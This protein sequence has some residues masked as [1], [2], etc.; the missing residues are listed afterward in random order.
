MSA[1]ACVAGH[2]PEPVGTQ[3]HH[4]V[5]VS[6]VRDGGIP[7]DP[8]TVALCGTAHDNVHALLNH[9][10]RRGG[11]PVWEIRRQFGPYIR[12]LAAIAWERRPNEKPP[13]TSASGE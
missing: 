13:W 2:S 8:E 4:V 1:C 3:R 6:W 5:P 11:L 10:V 9:Y 7:Y 12:E